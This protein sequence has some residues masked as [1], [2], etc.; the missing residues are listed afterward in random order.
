MLVAVNIDAAED[1]DNKLDD[2]LIGLILLL[3]LDF[4]LGL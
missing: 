3:T 1:F 4:T 2:K